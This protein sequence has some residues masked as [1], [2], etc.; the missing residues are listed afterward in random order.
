MA[1]SYPHA[2][3]YNSLELRTILLAYRSIEHED[4]IKKGAVG[5]ERPGFIS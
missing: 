2:G 5:G 3:P 1:Y 4:M